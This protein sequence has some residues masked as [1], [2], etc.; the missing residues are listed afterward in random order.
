MEGQLH[1][2]FKNTVTKKLRSQGYTLYTEPPTS[3]IERVWWTAYCPDILG[4][5][6]NPSTTQLTFVE[7]ETTPN[8]ARILEK[9]GKIQQ[10]LTLQ[11]RL[12]EQHRISLLLVIPP[13]KLSKINRPA[14]RKFWDIWIVNRQGK[15]AYTI[16]SRKNIKEPPIP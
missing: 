7:C 9:T 10:T 12:L 3:P 13:N 11:K 6:S 5:L 8:A 15:I 2:L 4:I 1:K 14:I 16:P